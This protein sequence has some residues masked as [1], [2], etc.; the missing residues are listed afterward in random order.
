MEVPMNKTL[1]HN[2]KGKVQ[3]ELLKD[4]QREYRESQINRVPH[5]N[6]DLAIIGLKQLDILEE[7]RESLKQNKE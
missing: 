2:T 3:S 5:S 4:I 6:V 7:I 1:F